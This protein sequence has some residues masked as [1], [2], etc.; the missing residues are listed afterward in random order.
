VGGLGAAASSQ[1]WIRIPCHA[2]RFAERV[3]LRM[4][5]QLRNLDREAPASRSWVRTAR[6][7][8]ALH[9]HTD[10]LLR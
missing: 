3:C 1:A 8:A 2:L 6:L 7:A 10:P 5:G 9:S 4:T